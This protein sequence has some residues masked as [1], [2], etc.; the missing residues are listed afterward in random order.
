MSLHIHFFNFGYLRK[1]NV[2]FGGLLQNKNKF[3]VNDSIIVKQKDLRAI[4]CDSNKARHIDVAMTDAEIL[5][6][7]RDNLEGQELLQNN[8]MGNKKSNSRKG[9]NNQ[10]A[11][12]QLYV[13]IPRRQLAP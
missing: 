2:V 10:K 1:H 7:S 5:R 12:S 3:Q 11:K 4:K 6:A 8:F 13:L 9:D